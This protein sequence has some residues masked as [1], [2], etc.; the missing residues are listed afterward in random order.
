VNQIKKMGDLKSL[1][2][3]IP[4]MGKLTKNLD[5]DNNAFNKVE[6]IIFSMTPYERSHPETLN[7]SRKT[8]IAGGCGQNIHEINQFIKQFEQMRK[9]MH[10]MTKNPSMMANFPGM[11]GGA[12]SFGQNRRK[13]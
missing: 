6:S 11:N 5:I 7:M 1:M 8:R 2:G 12:G 13:K 9:M 4:G 10:K 3:M